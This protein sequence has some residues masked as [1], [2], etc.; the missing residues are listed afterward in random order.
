[1]PERLG[2]ANMTMAL[3][4]SSHREVRTPGMTAMGRFEPLAPG[5]VRSMI[6]TGR[7]WLHRVDSGRSRFARSVTRILQ[8]QTS[9]RRHVDG[10]GR[11]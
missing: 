5:R 8:K 7:E 1:M 9:T 11:G 2:D 10:E 4:D 6:S 3:I